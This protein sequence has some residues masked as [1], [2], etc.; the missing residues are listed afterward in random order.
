MSSTAANFFSRM[1][2]DSRALALVASIDLKAEE[3]G[4]IAFAKKRTVPFVTY[5]AEELAQIEGDFTASGF[6]A[7]V[8][9]V[10]NVCERAV[11]AS[12]ADMLVGK[13]VFDGITLAL[14]MRPWT[15]S[16]DG[17]RA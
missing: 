7:E 13:T 9:G 6:V 5:S 11:V 8:T 2:V 17:G 12:G 16:F 3:S 14:G 4:I 10:D 15:V 1:H